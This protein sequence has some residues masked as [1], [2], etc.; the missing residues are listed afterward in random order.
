[1]LLIQSHLRFV[2]WLLVIQVSYCNNY[3]SDYQQIVSGVQRVNFNQLKNTAAASSDPLP[4]VLSLTGNAFPFLDVDGK[5]IAAGVKFGNGRIVVFAHDAYL[6]MPLGGRDQDGFEVLVTNALNWAVGPSTKVNIASYG[7]R[8]NYGTSWI[9]VDELENSACLKVIKCRTYYNEYTDPG[10]NLVLLWLIDGRDTLD[11]GYLRQL[12]AERGAGLVVG[13]L[14][15]T[16]AQQQA[17]DQGLEGT[18]DQVRRQDVSGFVGN[19]L[20]KNTG[21]QFTSDF[22]ATPTTME[23]KTATPEPELELPKPSPPAVDPPV[24]VEPP[25][26]Q[27]VVP[28]APPPPPPPPPQQQQPTGESSTSTANVGAVIGIVVAAVVLLALAAV[29]AIF[30]INRKKQRESTTQSN[31]TSPPPSSSSLFILKDSSLNDKP[32]LMPS[33]LLSS[34][35]Q[36]NNNNY[37]RSNNN[38]LPLSYDPLLSSISEALSQNNNN[39]NNINSSSKRTSLRSSHRGNSGSYREIAFESITFLKSIGEGSY[40]RVYLA[41]WD[42]AEVAIKVLTEKTFGSHTQSMSKAGGNS[43][44]SSLLPENLVSAMEKEAELMASLRHPN[45]VQFLGVCLMPPCYPAIITEWCGR[46]SVY[47]VLNAAQHSSGGQLAQYL[48]WKRRVKMAYDT[49]RGML[50]L[51]NHKPRSI[52]H[53]D[54]KSPNLLVAN[55]WTIKVADFN[56]SRLAEEHSGGGGGAFGSSVH[57]SG[58]GGPNNARWLAP[59]TIKGEPFTTASDVFSFGNVMWEFMFWNIPWKGVGD[60]QIALQVQAGKRP[61]VDVSKMPS[62]DLS[63]DMASVEGYIAT[64]KACLSQNPEERPQFAQIASQLR[65][66]MLD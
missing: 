12:V 44:S 62:V 26:D 39:S 19:I 52:I 2:L 4:S 16:M 53:R 49:A 64:M 1:M 33:S 57:A 18:A 38:E 35:F 24:E 27:Q 58:L 55:D 34:P 15:W 45:I 46:G 41:Q 51:H 29:T 9:N 56:L 7:I 14:A 50:Y 47:D 60:W 43:S 48:S 42:E 40:G 37:Y 59:E 32:H 66:L 31:V 23:L 10:V 11:V 13:A 28:A 63:K 22:L 54:L 3:A 6:Q 36:N 30:L 25:S 65:Q 5:V 17:L 61:P 20:L 8:D 21:I